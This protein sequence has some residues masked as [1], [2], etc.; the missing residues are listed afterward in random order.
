VRAGLARRGWPG[1][2]VDAESVPS[3]PESVDLVLR[4]T[5][6]PRVSFRWSGDPLDEKDRRKA[7]EAWPSYAS[8]DV[9][10]GLVARAALVPL[11][12]RGHYA[13]KV[14]PEVSASGD[15]VDVSLR[16]ALGA[17]GKGVRLEFEGNEALGDDAL[18]AALPK[19]GSRAFFE[20]LN[21]RSSGLTNA[22]RLAYARVGYV[23]A[24]ARPPRSEIDPAT[25]SLVVTFPL[26]ERRVSQIAE[27][28]LPE[29]IV[30]AGASGPALTLKTGVPFDVSAYVADRD[31]I[32]AWY[33]REGWLDARVAGFLE[34]G[35]AGVSVRFAATPGPR[36][37]VGAVRVTQDGRTG[38]RVRGEAVTLAPGDFIRPRALAES[39]ERLAELGIFRTVEVR[40]ERRAGEPEVRDIVVDLTTRPD[41]TVEYGV[42]YSTGGSGGAD[43][44]PSTPSGASLQLAGA[45]ELPNPFGWGW[46]IRGYSFLTTDRQ[47][48]GVNLDK[49]TF[50]GRR[51]RSQ[52]LVYDD[53]DD[54]I[55]VSSLTSRVK[56]VTL[57]QTKTLLRDLTTRRW[58]DRLRVQWGYTFKD[59]LYVE[60]A[61]KDTFLAGDRAF[62]SAA[63]IGDE[64]DSLT[65]PR[66]GVFWTATTELSRGFLGSDADYV[67]LYGQAFT[68][69]SLGP[70]VWAQG[71]RMGVVPGTDP[72]LLI[73]NR[74][75]AGGPTTVRGF[76]QNGL[77]PITVGDDS[78]GGQAVAVLNQE[79]RFP[80]WKRVHGGVFWDAGNVWLLARELRLGDLRQSVGGGLRVMFPF[81]PIR[82][83]YAWVL[84]P[85]PGE[86]KSRFVFGLGHA[87]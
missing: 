38:E 11:Q 20:A 58:H 2:T 4:V 71:Y 41:V 13:A 68:F 80:I 30:A 35:P 54:D 23:D 25:G 26:R 7:E 67:R 64:R 16:I 63:L 45:L 22:L 57:Q 49:A 10:A 17:K 77:G 53:S 1:A 32:G 59:I 31:A 51:L 5:P 40:P 6:G 46:H 50:F 9:A 12:A 47:N 15:D 75:R 55:V 62:L 82:L 19:P 39:R 60:N 8:P 79:L 78:L 44:G 65:D 18:A 69:L 52:V 3:G 37:Q 76:A 72:L 73:E 70:V 43:A 48:Y 36:P 33:R 42:R 81:G 61:T 84:K 24:R 56:G 83:E 74:F 28:E 85:K 29:E 27:I 21:G 87:F 86:S 14:V 66:H 34:P